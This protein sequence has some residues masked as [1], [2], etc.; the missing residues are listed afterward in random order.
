MIY[1]LKSPST[2]RKIQT[3]ALHI[4]AYDCTIEHIK[5]EKNVIAD[6]LSRMPSE[7]NT[8]NKG[9]DKDTQ[10]SVN[11]QG[12]SE[13][14]VPDAK[15]LS[16]RSLVVFRLYCLELSSVVRNVNAPGQGQ[17]KV[18]HVLEENI[19]ML[20]ISRKAIIRNRDALNDVIQS[21]RQMKD[22]LNKVSGRA[23][24]QVLELS[25]FISIY[26]RT[27]TAINQ[28]RL[29]V[30]ELGDHFQYLQLQ[31]NMLSV[32]HLSPSVIVP[33]E[34]LKLLLKIK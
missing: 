23:E 6:L 20:N 29:A 32:G 8:L 12:E 13:V 5:G 10:N 24:K 1:L 16:F 9:Y 4:S 14:D 18:V 15:D 28:L 7:H 22:V 17:K 21:V 3:W 34:F 27:N 25:Q 19:S 11:T 26:L 2:N 33:K 31:L 30:K